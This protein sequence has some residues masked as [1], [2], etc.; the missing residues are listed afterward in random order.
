MGRWRRQLAKGKRS[1][2]KLF[3]IQSTSTSTYYESTLTSPD[4]CR[5]YI[6]EQIA[7]AWTSLPQCHT[8]A[9][10]SLHSP[11]QTVHLMFASIES[12]KESDCNIL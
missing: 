12:L 2:T 10:R 7:I 4:K 9:R 5:G 6:L 1:L 3:T 11:Y 8:I